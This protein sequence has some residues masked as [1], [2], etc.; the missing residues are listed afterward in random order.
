VNTA[1]LRHHTPRASRLESLRRDSLRHKVPSYPVTVQHEVAR[2][3]EEQNNQFV[4]K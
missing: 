3:P 1:L 2:C 4:L